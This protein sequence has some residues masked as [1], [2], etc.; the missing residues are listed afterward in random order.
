MRIVLDTA[1]FVT[2][3]QSSDVAAPMTGAFPRF[4]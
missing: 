2:A 4:A 3:V 1:S